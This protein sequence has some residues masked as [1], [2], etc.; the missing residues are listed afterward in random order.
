MCLGYSQDL[1]SEV[2]RAFCRDKGLPLFRRAVGGGLVYLDDRQVFFQVI[3][4]APRGWRAVDSVYRECLRPAM[5]VLT[6]LGLES[7]FQP[8]ADLTVGGRKISGNG[9]GEIAGHAV[10]VGN[11]LIDFDFDLMAGS[12]NSPA[13]PFRRMVRERM[14]D[15]LTTLRRELGAAPP[16]L[17]LR[18]LFIE[19]FSRRFGPLRE[20]RY[21]HNLLNEFE[22]LEREMT[23][24]GWPDHSPR[25]V[26]G[27]DVKIC[28]GTYV[29]FREDPNRRVQAIWVEEAGVIAEVEIGGDLVA[30]GQESWRELERL[31][32]GCPLERSKIAETC[33][34]GV[35]RG[36]GAALAEI[37]APAP[38]IPEVRQ[39]A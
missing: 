11:I 2:D 16:R 37:L 17:L 12:L 1:D 4:P 25:T 32:K 18:R 24:P 38:A 30:Q 39:G 33:R 19:A 6:S 26:E 27:R 13:E 14:S 10:V 31:L 5:D 28:E 20:G 8:A 3:L 34:S 29:R 7:R 22:Q 21:D 15:H 9:G 23:D 35:G 36:R